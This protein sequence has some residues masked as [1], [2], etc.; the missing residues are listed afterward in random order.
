MSAGHMVIGASL[1]S[2]SRRIPAFSLS[3]VPVS[4]FLDITIGDGSYG[5]L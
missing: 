5:T 4:E 1:A 2:L 3:P